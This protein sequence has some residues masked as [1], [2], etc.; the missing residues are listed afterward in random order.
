MTARPSTE[1]LLS[2]QVSLFGACEA[3]V[4][5]LPGPTPMRPV[6]LYALLYLAGRYRTEPNPERKV[7]AQKL[8][9]RLIYLQVDLRVDTVAQRTG[10]A[11][12]VATALGLHDELAVLERLRASLGLPVDLAKTAARSLGQRWEGYARTRAA[13][14]EHGRKI[15]ARLEL[16]EGH[17]PWTHQL[18]ALALLAARDWR[19]IQ[20][21]DM[22]LGKTIV[23]ILALLER[24][25][26]GPTPFP[27]LVVCPSSVVETWALTAQ[28][29]L[30]RVPIRVC[31][32]KQGAH[33]EGSEIDDALTAGLRLSSLVQRGRLKDPGA[34]ARRQATILE[35]LP[36][37]LASSFEARP[38]GTV[39]ISPAA[40]EAW[41]KRPLLVV[42]SWG[43]FTRFGPQLGELRPQAV[44]LDEFHE[45]LVNPQSQTANL[46]NHLTA[47]SKPPLRLALSGTEMA[48]GRPISLYPIFRFLDRLP[49]QQKAMWAYGKRFCATNGRT[50]V[51]V[52]KN[53]DGTWKTRPDYS[54]RSNHMEFAGLLHSASVRRLKA[55]CLRHGE[56]PPKT[57]FG[58]HI[59]L[60]LQDRMA[61]ARV[62]DEVKV[63]VLKKEF[64]A[65]AHWMEEGLE[66]EAIE[67]KVRQAVQSQMMALTHRLREALGTIKAKGAKPLLKELIKQG[68]RPIIFFELLGCASEARMLYEDLFGEGEVFLGTGQTPTGQRQKLVD[69]WES[70]S[71]KVLVL[72]RA[73]AKAV[74]L[75]SGRTVIFGQRFQRPADELQAEDRVN[76]IGQTRDTH[77]YMLHAPGTL[78]DAMAEK[79][80]WKESGM[81]GL[82]GSTDQR[83]FE[84]LKR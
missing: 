54:G 40:R 9:L 24:H 80:A 47:V 31:I 8:R 76:R 17:R 18:E 2:L 69:R 32:L 56:L 55:E 11:L 78:D 14:T 81:L 25:L 30:S 64:E 75:V 29:W 22:G 35:Q 77:V 44:I 12:G 43:Q 62:E 42:G 84:W 70:G 33:F 52:G 53:P 57:R 26:H 60:S 4:A 38:D 41:V 36:S 58:L 27:G 15:G 67:H 63:E 79:L 73:F 19:A 37:E 7:R 82:R 5:D 51:I 65:R 46:L 23:A 61:L 6:E 48:N 49:P 59:H 50:S 74:T 34:V 66:P 72:T 20:G 16:P 39:W 68:E 71:G 45:Y 10:L 28:S 83:V 1:E 21:D 13:I 3:L